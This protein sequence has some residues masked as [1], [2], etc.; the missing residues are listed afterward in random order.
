MSPSKLTVE[1]WPVTHPGQAEVNEDTVLIYQPAD[2]DT[3]RL[4][5]SMYVLADGLGGASRGQQASRYAAQRIIQLYYA[6]DEPDLGLRL[7]E[8]I[9]LDS[10]DVPVTGANA[11]RKCHLLPIGCPQGIVVVTI[12]SKRA[13]AVTLH[14]IEPKL[15]VTAVLVYHD[16]DPVSVRR[17]PWVVIKHLV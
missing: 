5:G 2:P 8:A 3:L 9:G 13:A 6:S 14:L 16:G 17:Q 1:V 7:R 12:A 10:I 15:M 4:Q 11:R